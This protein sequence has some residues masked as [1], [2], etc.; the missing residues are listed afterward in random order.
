MVHNN[1]HFSS[2]RDGRIYKLNLKLK[3][4]KAK[5]KDYSSLMYSSRFL[6]SFKYITLNF[7]LLVIISILNYYCKNSAKIKTKQKKPKLLF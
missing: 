3:T 6:V 1:Y 5:F 4:V 2:V 7:S